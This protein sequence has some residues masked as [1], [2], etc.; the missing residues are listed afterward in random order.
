MNLA[1]FSDGIG[2]ARSRCV[3]KGAESP[4]DRKDPVSQLADLIERY[5]EE[6]S[7]RFAVRSKET[8]VA[9]SLDDEQVIDSLRD[10]LDEIVRGLRAEE[11][12]SA[13]QGN[14]PRSEGASKHGKQ[15]FELGFDF[16]VVVR[17]YGSIRDILF[18][19]R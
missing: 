16:A 13:P 9:Q 11:T 18:G 8:F 14:P 15:R 6:I 5:T 19:D 17:E 1:R 2:L 3:A 7:Q 12:Q 4:D 10:F